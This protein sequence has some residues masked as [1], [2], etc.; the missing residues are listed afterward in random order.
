MKRRTRILIVV[1][2]AI[3]VLG[4]L[5]A[6]FVIS[7]APAQ[8]GVEVSSQPCIAS[9]DACLRFP[10]ISGGSLTGQAYNLPEDFAGKRTLVIV[11]FNEDQ[12]VKAAGWL[13][14]AKELAAAHPDF[15]YYNV[16]I[17]P[18]MAAPLRALIR[19]GMNFTISDADLR[20]I[21]ITVFLDD[22]DAFLAA[23]DVANTDAMQVFL[24][25]DED[26]LLW[27][28]VGEFSDAQGEALRALL[29]S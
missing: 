3:A 8:S 28:G 10:V 13:P 5:A 22:R 23:L 26:T 17:F 20:A 25:G 6:A 27:R 21:T 2:A 11:P 7:R 9:G 1:I 4:V 15:A 16:P 14:L 24:L 29:A 12:Q 19:T 18:G